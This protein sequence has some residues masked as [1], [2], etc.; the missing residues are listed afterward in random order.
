MLLGNLGSPDDV[1][2]DCAGRVATRRWSLD[3]V[4]SAGDRW[5]E[6]ASAAASG[7]SVSQHRPGGPP[8]VETSLRVTG[9]QLV[10]RTWCA[11]AGGVEVVVVEIENR[12]PDAVGIGLL[13][14]TADRTAGFDGSRA[15]TVD[16]R[17]VAAVGRGPARLAVG[18]VGDVRSVLTSGAAPAP[19]G[20]VDGA[21]AVAAV[22]PLAHTARLRVVGTPF[23]PWTAV[24][25]DLEL[26]PGADEVARGWRTHLDAGVRLTAPD[27]A[28][29]SALDAA[30]ASLLIGHDR[31]RP[32]ADT[33][34]IG[35]A[36]GLWGHG[37]AAATTLAD[38]VEHQRL[39]GG[40]GDRR[41]TA[42]TAIVLFALASWALAEQDRGAPPGDLDDL[43]G[44]VAKAAHRLARRHRSGDLPPWFG[45]AQLAAAVL[46]DRA[47]QPEAA[48]LCRERI[49]GTHPS[50]VLHEVE[51]AVPALDTV[52]GTDSHA[53]AR[54]LVASRRF[55]VD[56]TEPSVLRLVN[57]FPDDWLGQDLEVH[58]LPTASGS[59]S[60]AVRWHGPRPAILWE[61]EPVGPGGPPTIV[62]GL[63]PG[64]SDE[65]PAGE[66]LLGPVEP[67]GGLP[68]V[69]AP[70][71][72]A[73]TPA[74][75]AAGGEAS[76]S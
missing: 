45:P 43:A 68:K 37:D 57:R 55:L 29:T 41:D 11:H 52:A 44:P 56:D 14:E 74:A 34:W 47:G 60:F 53:S 22:F 48:E 49:A 32:L 66:A 76:F 18:E 25:A 63:D 59:L 28:F 26:V 50:A 6:P 54:F 64:W 16:G 1:T 30:R 51:L 12:S 33:A 69:V 27:P 36:L 7:T 72:A 21:A 8:V 71:P 17:P 9:G 4:V 31:S 61:L 10:H 2:V 65:R 38:I 46:L 3:W 40:F 23:G 67:A 19:A 58:H 5:V 62:V 24:P 20:A 35:L 42:T 15:L 39:D 75:E 73:G 70:L 13:L